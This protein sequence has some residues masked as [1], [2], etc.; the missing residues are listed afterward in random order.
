MFIDFPLN[1]E[2]S[3]WTWLPWLV[4]SKLIGTIDM[5][6]MVLVMILA[7]LLPF[8]QFSRVYQ[9][10]RHRAFVQT[11][12]CNPII[13]TYIASSVVSSK[14][15]YQPIQTFLIYIVIIFL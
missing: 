12:F 8:I 7:K 6:K 11:M 10:P 13:V 1:T 14:F 4:D 15:R 2:I 9:P 5:W 3:M